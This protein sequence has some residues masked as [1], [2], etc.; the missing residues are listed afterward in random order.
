LKE[1]NRVY[2]YLNDNNNY[3]MHRSTQTGCVTYNEHIQINA[4][5]ET[6]DKGIEYLVNI[7]FSI[8]TDNFSPFDNTA[9]M[10]KMDN[11]KCPN[12][13]M[14][15]LSHALQK[16]LE[17]RGENLTFKEC[18]V[19]V[20]E[21]A[22][23][24]KKDKT[25]NIEWLRKW[26][27]KKGESV[28]D[29]AEKIFGGKCKSGRKQHSG[30]LKQPSLTLFILFSP[31]SLFNAAALT[32]LFKYMETTSQDEFEDIISKKDNPRKAYKYLGEVFEAFDASDASNP[33]LFF[34]EVQY[35]TKLCVDIL[36]VSSSCFPPVLSSPMAR[37]L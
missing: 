8:D 34:D 7:G 4:A 29:T 5:Y 9:H 37:H 24:V 17:G 21:F 31:P 16:F 23:S 25:A 36:S 1:F 22:R 18:H 2:K 28:N 30:K 12:G 19:I 3:H 10:H 6:T 20:C 11:Q 26:C 33:N 32:D 27:D 35:Y 15:I 13:L 14:P